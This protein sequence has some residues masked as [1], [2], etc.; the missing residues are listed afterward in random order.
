MDRFTQFPAIQRQAVADETGIACI[1][2]AWPAETAALP[3]EILGLAWAVLLRAFTTEEAPVFLLDGSPVKVDTLTQ[4]IRPA[5]LDPIE[6][7]AEHTAVHLTDDPARVCEELSNGS[8]KDQKLPSELCTLTWHFNRKAQTSTLQATTGMDSN[9]IQQL[10]CQLE[11]IVRDQASLSGIAV[12][13]SPLANQNSETTMRLSIA[14]PSPRNLAG[15]QLLHELALCNTTSENDAIEFM[16]ADRAV[17]RLSYR[18]LDQASTRLAARIST[19]ATTTRTQAEQRQMVVPIL[20]PQSLELYITQLAILKAGGAFCP[21]TI[22]APSDRIE[23]IIQDVAAAVIV[24]QDALTTRIPK[25]SNV[26]VITVDELE[27]HLESHNSTGTIE[28]V[29]A[30]TIAPTDLAYVMYTSGSTG[31][32]KG[33]GISHLAATQSLLAHNELIPQFARFLQFASPTFDVSVFEIFFPLFRGVTLVACEREQMLLDISRVMTTMRVDAAELTPTVA[34]ELLRT[35]SA[36]PSL[37][38]LLTIGEML[39]R[40][41]V[42]EFASSPNGEDGILHGMYGPT[43]A[44]IHCTAATQFHSDDRVNLIGR[45]FSTVSG[46][47]MPIYSDDET[48]TKVDELRPLPLGQIGE[49]VVGGPQLADGYINRPEENAKAFIDSP[50]YGRLYRTGDKARMLPSGEIECFG[51]ISSGQVKLRGQRIELGEIEHAICQTPGARSAVAVVSNGSLAAFVLVNSKETTERTL[52]DVCRQWLPR[53]MVPGEFILVNQFPQLPSGKID[54]KL[55]EA[56][57]KRHRSNAQAAKDYKFRDELEETIASCVASVMGRQVS[58]IESLGAAGLDSLAAIRLASHL[59][60]SGIRLDVAHLLEADSVNGIWELARTAE[61]VAST[62]NTS[63][64]LQLIHQLVADAGAA[65][66]EA[67]GLSSKVGA[68][69]LCSHIQQAMIMETARQ[70]QA[71]CNCIELEF[72]PETRFSDIQHAIVKLLESNPILRSGFVEIGLKDQAYARFVYN[73]AELDVLHQRETFNYGFSLMVESDLLNPLQ[74]YFREAES[75]PRL[76]VQIHH[77][78][79]DGWSWQLIMRDLRQLL[80]GEAIEPRPSYTLISDFFAEHKLGHS[81][82]NSLNFWRDRLQGSPV[83]PF[84]KFVASVTPVGTQ[85]ASRD[86]QISIERLAEASQTLHVSRQ[87]I[88]QAAYCYLLSTYLGS[89]DVTFGTV[90]SGRTLPVKGIE[91]VL[92]PCIRTL[93]TRMAMGQMRTVADLLLAIQNM[94]HRCLEHGSVSLQDIKKASEIDPRASLFDTAFV[95]QETLWQT[96]KKDEIFK[97]VKE[98]EFLEFAVLLELEPLE[99]DVR[100]KITFQQSILSREQAQFLLEQ[101]DAVVAVILEAPTLVIEEIGQR[102]PINILSIADSE[103]VTHDGLSEILGPLATMGPDLEAVKILSSWESDTPCFD[104]ITYGQLANQANGHAEYLS[105]VGV[106]KSDPVLLVLTQSIES[107]IV[108]L[109]LAKLGAHLISLSP[110]TTSEDLS[111]VV[112]DMHVKYYLS[113]SSRE[114]ELGFAIPGS[115]QQISLPESFEAPD[116]IPHAA[117]D[118]FRFSTFDPTIKDWA[119]FTSPQLG[120][121][122]GIFRKSYDLTHEA[123]IFSTGSAAFPVPIIE[124]MLAWSAGAVLISASSD[125]IAGDSHKVLQGMGLTHLHTTPTLASRLDP[126][127]FPTI[128]ELY[129]SGEPLTVKVQRKWV[130]TNIYYGY[131]CSNF[132]GPCTGLVKLDTIDESKNLGRPNRNTSLLVIADSVGLQPVP[133]GAAGQ[134]CFGGNQLAETSSKKVLQHAEL[135]KFYK[136]NDIARFLADGTVEIIGQTATFRRIEQVLLSSKHVQDCTSL[137][138]EI[139]TSKSPQL[140]TVWVPA[141]TARTSDDLVEHSLE[142][143]RD[144]TS[145]LPSSEVPSYL[146]PVPIIAMTEG[147]LTD[148]TDVSNIVKRLGPETLRQYSAVPDDSAQDEILSDTEKSISTALSKVLDLDERIIGRHTSFYKL[149]LDSLSAIALSRQLQESGIGRL[150]VSTILRYNSVSQLADIAATTSETRQVFTTQSVGR[151]LEVFDSD[152]VSAV[153]SDISC[154]ASSVQGVYPCTPLQEAMLAA[155][156]DNGTAYFNHLLLRVNVSPDTMKEAWLQMIQRHGIL[157]SCFRQTNHKRFAYAQIVLDSATLPWTEK[158]TAPDTFKQDIAVL[159]EDFERLSPV[160]GKLPYSLTFLEDASSG[161]AY[162]LLSIHHAL[163]DGEGIAQLLDEVQTVLAGGALAS[164]TPFHRF[165]EYMVSIDSDA[166]DQF[167]DRYLSSVSPTLLLSAQENSATEISELQAASQQISMHLNLTLEVFKKQCQDLSVTPLNV[168]HAAWARLL[169]LQSGAP[170]VC[171]GNVFS[172]R[173]IPLE[174][175]DKIVGPCFNTLPMRVRFTSSATNKDIMRLAQTH[176]SDI[177][178]H[179]LS[180]LRHIQ[181]RVLQGN[182]R[183]FDTLLIFQS[184]ANQLDSRFWEILGDEGNMGF[185]LI[186]EV[187]PDEERNLL[188]VCVYFQQSHVSREAAEILATDFLAIVEQ[189]MQY[190]SAQAWD[191]RAITSD[192]SAMFDSRLSSVM[193]VDD[194][195]ERVSDSRSWSTHEELLRKMICEFAETE[196]NAVT[197]GTTIFQLGLDSINAVQLSGKLHKMGHPISAGDILEAAS[198]EKIA[199]LFNQSD[200]KGVE[201]EYDFSAFENEHLRTVCEQ[202]GIAQDSVQ[203]LRPCTPVQSGMLALFNHSQGDMYYNRMVLNAPA[204]LE[205]AKLREAWSLV[206]AHHEMLRTGFVQLRDQNYPFA[207]VTYRA[208]FELPWRETSGPDIVAREQSILRTLHLPPWEVRVEPGDCVST[209][210]FSALHALYDAQSLE[211]VFSDVLAVYEGRSLPGSAPLNDTLGP[212]LIES[213]KQSKSSRSFWESLATELN[214]T[215]FPDLH[216]TRTTEKYLLTRSIRCSLPLTDLESACRAAGVT[217]QAA[218]QVAW[219]RL[220][221]A[222]TGEQNVTF[223]TV[224]SGR[225]LSQAA[226]QAVFPCLVTVPSLIQTDCSNRVL[227]HRTLKRNA[228]LTRHQFTPLGR[229]Q[230][231]FGSDEPLFDTLFVYQKFAK[232]TSPKSSSWEVVDVET[233]IDYPVSIELLPQAEELEVRIS[234]RSDLVPTEQ[235]GLILDQFDRLLKHTVL[236]PDSAAT[237]YLSLGN[238]LLSVTPAKEILI[239]TEVALLHQFVEESAR[240]YPERPAFE[241][242]YGPNADSL[243]KK[244]WSYKEFNADGNRVAH[245]LK[246][247]GVRAGSIVGICFDKCPEASLAILGILKAGCAYLAIDPSAPISRKQFILEDSATKVLLCDQSR[248]SELEALSGVL[249]QTIDVA[250]NIQQ[251]S[252]GKLVLARDITP[253]DT[254]YCLYTSGTTG[255]PKG[256]EITHGNAVQAMLAFQRLFAP[257]WDET[258]RWLQFASFHFDVSVLEQYWSWSVGICVTSCPRDLLFEDLPGTIHKLGIT[259][260]DLTPSLARLVHPDDVPSLCR[261]V[262]ITGGEQLKQEILDA[263]GEHGVIYNGYGPTEATIGCTMLPRMRANDKPSNIGPQFDNVGSYVFKAGTCTPVLRGG[264]GELCVSGPLVGKGY[265]NRAELTQERFQTLD[266]GDRIYR[267]G[268]LVRILHDGSFQFLGRIDDQVKLRGQ[269]LEIGEINEVIKQATPELN[270]VATLVVKHPKQSKD[271]LVSFVTAKHVGKKP[272]GVEVRYSEDD[273]SVLVAVKTACYSRLPGY[274]VPTH[275]IPMTNFPLSANNKADMKVLKGIYQE[276]SLEDLQR[277]GSIALDEN[278]QSGC[279]KEIISILAKFTKSPEPAISSWT[280]IFELG[281]DS[282]SVISFA[283]TLREAGFSQAQASLI[284]KH[285][286]VA[287]LSSVLKQST[288]VSNLQ[289]RLRLSS[290][291]KID[292]FT[293]KHAHSV[294]E[295]IGV[296]ESLV[297]RI[298]PCTPLQEGIIY[299]FL[300]SP[301]PLYCSS[302]KFALHESVDIKTLKDSWSKAQD[303]L[304]L[305]RA[306]FSPTSDGYAQVA[307]KRD[308]LAWFVEDAAS[309]DLIEDVRRRRFQR[310]TSCLAGLPNQLWEVGVVRSS[311]KSVMCLNIFHALYDG[312]SLELILDLVAN[313]YLGR[314][315]QLRDGPQFL[316][317]L[318][319][320]P[321]CE[322]PGEEGFWKEHLKDVPQKVLPQ[323]NDMAAGNTFLVRKMSIETTEPLNQLTKTL[324]VTEQAVLHACWLLTLHQQY[325]FVPPLGI[326]ASGRASDTVDL[327]NVIGPLFNTIPS[328]VRFHGLGSWAEVARKC[329]DYHVSSMSFQ[330]TALRN[331]MKWLGKCPDESLF[332]SLFV[333]QKDNGVTESSQKALWTPLDSDAS[334]EYPL[335]FEIVR[336]G[337][338]SLDMTLAAQEKYVPAAVAEQ[339]LLKFQRNLSDFSQNPDH[340]LSYSNGFEMA[341]QDKDIQSDSLRRDVNGV[342]GANGTHVLSTED[343]QFEWSDQASTIRTTIAALADVDMQSIDEDTSIFEVGLDSIDAIKLSSRLAKSGVKL[344]VSIIMRYRT[345]KGMVSQLTNANTQEQN[346]APSMLRQMEAS[347]ATFLKNEGLMPKSA[348]RVLP[349]TPLQ[350]AMIAEMVASEYQNYYNHDILQIERHVNIAQLQRS[351]EAVVKEHPILRTSFVEVWDPRIPVSFAQVIHD[352]DTFDFQTVHLNGASLESVIES[353]RQRA[354]SALAGKPLLSLTAAINDDDQYLILSISHALYDGWSINLLHEDIRRSYNGE[355]CTRPL[356]DAILGQILASSGDRAFRFWRTTLSNLTPVPFPSGEHGE[357]GSEAIHRSEKAL[358]VSS[359]KAETFCKRHGITMQALMV[360]CWSLVLSSYVQCLDVVFGLVLSG[361]NAADADKVMFPTMNTVAMRVLLHGSRLEL[362]KYVQ[363]TLLEISEYQHFPLRR[364]RPDTKSQQLFDTLFIYQKRPPGVSVDSQPLYRS[365][366][367]SSSVEYPICAEVEGEGAD[368]IARVACRGDVFGNKDTE[369]LLDRMAQA[370]LYVV[371]EPEKPTIQFADDA[372]TV[373]GRPVLQRQSDDAARPSQPCHDA[374][375]RSEWTNI[376]SSIRSVLSSVSGIPEDSIGKGTNI[377]EL[378]L[379][380]ISAIKVVALLKKQSIKLVVSDMLK[381][382]TVERMALAVNQEQLEISQHQ[383]DRAL[384]ESLEG[385]DLSLLLDTHGIDTQYVEQKLPA[386]AGQSYFLA[387]HSLNSHVFY[388]KFYYMASLDLETGSLNRAWSSLISEFPILRTAFLATG[389]SHLPFLQVVLRSVQ[390]APIWHDNLDHAIS[391]NQPLGSPPVALHVSRTPRG[392]VFMLHIHHALYDAV[393]LPLIVARLAQLCSERPPAAQLGHDLSHLVGFQRIISPIDVRRQFWQ[394]YLGHSQSVD[395]P[396]SQTRES[397]I[398][399]DYQPGLVSN[400]SR[401]DKAA[402]RQGLSTQSIFLAIY[403]RIHHQIMASDTVNGASAPHQL[404]VGLYLANRSYAIEGLSELVAPTVNIVPLRLDDK[405]SHDSTSL[406][407]AA[408]RIQQDIHAISSEEN[409]GVSLMEIAEWTGIRISTCINFL[410][411]P[412]SDDPNGDDASDVVIFKPISREELDEIHTSSSSDDPAHMNGD[413]VA[414]NTDRAIG[415][416]ASLAALKE[417]FLP[418]IDIEAAI[419]DDHLDFGV[420]APDTRLDRHK[421]R[422]LMDTMKAEMTSLIEAC[423]LA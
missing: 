41:V 345:V 288:P 395:L 401:L 12:R 102:L 5:T 196:T 159:K 412:E 294:I 26:T 152:F 98:R 267:T 48:D 348:R 253:D 353:Q 168:L 373:L 123:R 404:V 195:A 16:A 207:M 363:D 122:L 291:H 35:R 30:R 83:A 175:A 73:P 231:W 398:R 60:D 57:F 281:L 297:E 66:I 385:L 354:H 87:T 316:D 389:L 162:L 319:F 378:G 307:L 184:T 67:L 117:Y 17:Y 166:S 186:C 415:I 14:N 315:N 357:P 71:Y 334:H 333:F 295:S 86:L 312:N 376:E 392:V 8:A 286:T 97:E 309:A 275:I 140:V 341:S 321:L 265:L 115:V 282:I 18:A 368:L 262:F 292:A 342:N 37:R 416:N 120:D 405:H 180:A 343:F 116:E 235:A 20:L 169:A 44:A 7:S 54:R 222:L 382:G 285:P 370:L 421:A 304:Q 261:G 362:I 55:L 177:L 278:A 284:M 2:Q 194:T 104:S 124:S 193:E 84:P 22:D 72:L 252:A 182:S 251:Y 360:S 33:V 218:G 61:A 365:V 206:M 335:A 249:V 290:K 58:A 229:I 293:H 371:D 300:S 129:V 114:S 200:N 4:E 391:V 178:P 13:W 52:R 311:D 149:G 171:F 238:Q 256:C 240:R 296:D 96:K 340:E 254:C 379:D 131:T 419:R 23:F 302:F 248:C 216:P 3:T 143:L 257:H 167:W 225:N 53:F 308:E 28:Q 380:S 62:E 399:H 303:R 347:L 90:F 394:R 112:S 79:Y 132:A 188:R 255:T 264:L 174:G 74:F 274:M 305:L 287:G 386:T 49:L 42:D 89:D 147:F 283:R 134:L 349:A 70:R 263:W 204:P 420:F 323:L 11:H 220:L 40:A 217:L 352:E 63:A 232:Q 9:Y 136:T 244:V 271:Q 113:G 276:L 156:S 298:A 144:L 272:N 361:R 141:E 139:S 126:S 367:G 320:G 153:K 1:S 170:D 100:A 250:G 400:M 417:V 173:T 43:E 418:T 388:S 226:Q 239:P 155:E 407:A 374:P 157:R 192:L 197:L 273:R 339:L 109:A 359:V 39:T 396:N 372:M 356:S 85:E 280:S 306:R 228:A 75:G 158:K 408:H 369:A 268:D 411:L 203:A 317:A 154:G 82:I 142:L 92:G 138:M 269:R 413:R 328:N 128:R 324:N 163:Y 213:E 330:H 91:S 289:S 208:G 38:V 151:S 381:A 233:K 191:K 384:D 224:L 410:R 51:R 397:A 165:I 332:D 36:A 199:A 241:F 227:L 246:E 46:F 29:H 137:W 119:S 105:Q 210:H 259:H 6:F 172:C 80:S 130:G 198:I 212:I 377:F 135:G 121:C 422:K 277:L 50:V 336:N 181:R 77:A 161:K 69:D 366:G 103:D 215:K 314:V 403:A 247:Q 47:I 355:S 111:S 326:V 160:D 15:P 423:E 242:A 78:L 209:V 364:A 205:K 337:N 279:E 344:P 237:D 27:S 327:S 99:T 146:V 201:L 110:R 351:W 331:I 346:G 187:V 329:H 387:M 406:L 21:L 101:L 185:P 10:G 65:R 270:E 325:A 56:D 189:M 214:S 190:P 266:N 313:L 118:S 322:T 236:S 32:P 393:S 148:H 25:G 219:G 310:W 59:L 133:R 106:M 183:L 125:A 176:N 164:V 88:F 338:E 150:P 179:Q 93:P 202:L 76:L 243:Q 318:H 94:N 34:G 301:K 24:T 230:K 258:S 81:Y 234:C 64:G 390:N 223:G 383:I 95:W 108:L 145:K 31:R 68:V 375:K 45:V 402:N 414:S 350:E 19:A 299:H 245:L 409:A 211:T 358:A 260:I 127:N 221:A 107:Y